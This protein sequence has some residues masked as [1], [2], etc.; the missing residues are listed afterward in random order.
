MPERKTFSLRRLNKVSLFRDTQSPKFEL[1]SYDSGR[2]QTKVKLCRIDNETY[3]KIEVYHESKWLT[4]EKRNFFMS[5]IDGLETYECHEK[6]INLTE[7]KSIWKLQRYVFDFDEQIGATARS[8]LYYMTFLDPNDRQINESIQT[9]IFFWV[10]DS[11]ITM[12]VWRDGK[13]FFF[14]NDFEWNPLEWQR[15]RAYVNDF[16]SHERKWNT[17]KEEYDMTYFSVGDTD[18]FSEEVVLWVTNDQ[19]ILEVDLESKVNGAF[20]KTFVNN[21]YEWDGKYDSFFITSAS[22]THLTYVSSKWNGWISP[23]NFWYTVWNYWWGARSENADD[24]LLQQWG[25]KE[26]ELYAHMY[27]DRRLYLPGE[28]VEIKSILRNSK[29]L[30]I[31][32]DKELTLR[33]QDSKQKQILEIEKTIGEFG[34]I[35]ETYKLP[36][37]AILGE[38]SI[39]VFD[40]RDEIVTTSFSV[41]VFKNPKFKNEI[42]LETTGLNDELVNITDTKV[43]KTTWGYERKTHTWKFSIDA[44]VI[45]EYY[46]GSP[47]KNADFTYKVYKQDYHWEDFWNDCFF[48][49]Y[50]QPQKEFYTEGKGKLDENWTA[51]FKVDV[52]FSS[53]YADYKYIVEVTTE[54]KV[55]DSISGTNSIV[56][57]LPGSYKSWNPDSG[58]NFT[59]E[60]RYYKQGEKL[61][62]DGSLNFGKFTTDYNDVFLFIIKKKNY[63][64][65]YVDDVRWYKR[66]VTNVEEK[67]EDILKVN[68]SNFR[69]SSEWKLELD[70][71]MLQTGEYVFEFGKINEKL[72][73]EADALIQEFQTSKEWTLEKEFSGELEKSPDSLTN[74][75]KFCD[76]SKQDCSREALMKEMGCSKIFHHTSSTWK[77]SSSIGFDYDTCTGK[78]KVQIQMSQKIRVSDLIDP[79]S[80][81]YISLIAYG[82]QEA[83]NPIQSDNKITVLSENIV[84][85]YGDT[86]R[87]LIRLPFSKWKILWTVEKQW[88]LEHEYIDVSSNTFF[89]EVLVD[90]SFLPNAYI[91]VVAIDTD[92]EEIPEYKVGYTEIVVDKTDKKTDI[93]I[94]SD[95]KTYE[96][97]EEVTLDIDITCPSHQGGCP[98]GGGSHE[99]TVMVVDDSLISLMG[100]IDSN[101]LEKFYKKLPFQIQT[102]ITNIAMLRNYYFSRK[103][104]VGWSGFGNFKWGDSAVSSR[105]IFKNTAYYDPSVITDTNGKTQVKFTLPD[106]LTNFR[107]MVL[108]NSKDNFF[109]YA[110]EFIE[111]R[112]DVIIEDKTPLTIRDGDEVE[113]LAQIFNTTKNDIGFKGTLISENLDIDIAERLI[114]VRAGDSSI[115]RW[116]VKNTSACNSTLE[117]CHI[118]YMMTILWDSAKNSDKIEGKIEIKSAPSLLQTS[119][120]S[121]ILIT[122]ESHDFSLDLEENVDTSKSVYQLSISNSP[123][124]G[125]EKIVGSLAVYPFGCGEQ[126]LSSTM[127]NAVLQRYEWVY[128]NLEAWADDIQENVDAWLEKIY[129]MALPDGGFKYWESS[130]EWDV[131]IT[132]YALRVLSL[133]EE[134]GT[135]VDAEIINGAVEFLKKNYKEA[136]GIAKS[137]ALWALARHYGETTAEELKLTDLTFGYD[138]DT[139]PRHELIAYTHALIL[140]DKEKYK[141]VI[142]RNIQIIRWL[143]EVGPEGSYY[144]SKLSDTAE[145]VQI[146]I[147]FDYDK[148]V[149]SEYIQQLNNVDWSSYYRSTKTKANVFLSF[150]D[151]IEKYGKTHTTDVRLS[152]N[153]ESKEIEIGGENNVFSSKKILSEVLKDKKV[154]L[155][156][157][158]ISG[159]PL[160]V[161]AVIEEYPADPLKVQAYANNI[162]IKRSIYEV[163][164]EKDVTEKCTWNNGNRTCT[165]PSWLKL[166]TSDEF[167]KWTTYKIVLEAQFTKNWQRQNVTL[168][169]YLPSGFRILNSNFKTNSIATNQDST[170]ETWEWTHVEK[171][172]DLI[173]AHAENSWGT[174]STYE[175]YV[176]ADFAGSFIYPPA[177]GYQMYQ[178]EN[179]ANG[180]YRRIEIK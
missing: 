155:Q 73:F 43:E 120:V 175:Y 176:T 4:E 126:L 107:V 60:K 75:V 31:P 40:G 156:V 100:N 50:W 142:S 104:I 90:E 99:L 147:A 134:S 27:T 86:A 29:D 87:V 124:L 22:D 5:D 56:A 51:Q 157:D 180:E 149:I 122:G 109:G 2:D 23:W 125:I 158:N 58:I 61:I 110:E 98:E 70:Y 46:S 17:G 97:R 65:E 25:R 9:P 7:V 12:K 72:M 115:L 165:Q 76:I 128:K 113:V 108:S 44:S 88:V 24:I 85:K 57:K 168:E 78:Q 19:W 153:G 178:P 49:C 13:A 34:S 10:I 164:D 129:D 32:K 20:D 138:T 96:P 146:L 93:S 141:V 132:S 133:I 140:V 119:M 77:N 159:D 36:D 118:P 62:F 152:L 92:G 48:W 47:V 67:V 172:P 95:K 1:V 91:G 54:D 74:L 3:A 59:T 170:G 114:T 169:D 68:S 79:D 28:E 39:T 45:S 8:G 15:I 154:G 69:I 162:D 101:T 35:H 37:D 148:A 121:K 173:M 174:T 83:S 105:N 21:G 30:S 131:H 26:P 84:Y 143:V 139:M 177:T 6:Q 150:I 42:M 81:K 151:Y 171:R 66:P 106:N 41:E 82:Q 111:V 137:E 80:R 179:R 127:P 144:Y 112:K 16:K 166:H 102:S 89:K 52:D 145:L 71:T 160:F 123:L 117:T 161:N 53:L 135:Q 38:Y 116:R 167:K 63:I 33:V 103:W 64:T 136:T 94:N 14:V 130:S 11:H 55:G 18:I 163:I